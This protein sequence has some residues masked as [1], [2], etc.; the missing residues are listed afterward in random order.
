MKVKITE[1]LG[2]K[3]I[4]IYI[5]L[6]VITISFIITI[7]FENQVELI[8][9]N[10]RLETEK[11]LYALTV[12]MKKFIREM[13]Q[14]SLFSNDSG[15]SYTNNI[16][17]IIQQHS[18]EFI[19]FTNSGEILHQSKDN[20]LIPD[21]LIQDGL[22]SVTA[23][24]FTG[25]DYYLRIDEHRNIMYF[26]MPLD[27]TASGGSILL[28]TKDISKPEKALGDLYRQALYV[29]FVVLFFHLV[30]ALVLYRNIIHPIALLNRSSR[31]LSSGD[32]D[33]RVSIKRNDEIG[34]LADNFN[35]MAESIYNNVSRL[36]NRV[37][38][39]SE[40]VEKSSEISIREGL[41]GLYSR[42]YMLARLE[43]ETRRAKNQ[44]Y[45]LGF[46]LVDID[47]FNEIDK[48]YGQQ[49]GNI[50]IKEVA[51]AIKKSSRD[52]DIVARFS[53]E[54]F[55]VIA[56]ECSTENL[57]ILGERIRETVEKKKSITPDGEFTVT[58]S[59]GCTGLESEDEGDHPGI[60]NIIEAAESALRQ[61]KAGGRNR[62][63][64]G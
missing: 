61:A 41:T 21:G 48:I 33:A 15:T 5:I 62:V 51:K 45:D 22:R 30:F 35:R 11:Q 57:K 27:V 23:K 4:I 39:I 52:I 37:S 18:D 55:A 13:K 50:I 26:Y 54:E 29:I 58:V 24:T 2:F 28:L 10:T 64:T 43:E 40:S 20:T 36:K 12:S 1:S 7:I 14:G 60:K 38:T 34:S 25:K 42:Q 3:I 46:L 63:K 49:T 32:L 47:H 53:G 9:R 19:I 16:V 44:D 17:S 59:I 6:A 56:P 31:L 8:T